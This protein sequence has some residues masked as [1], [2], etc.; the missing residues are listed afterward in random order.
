MSKNNSRK[1]VER[2]SQ[3]YTFSLGLS[4][5]FSVNCF[6]T[7]HLQFTM[8]RN[9]KG[10][11]GEE[12]RRTP[13]EKKTQAPDNIT[14]FVHKVLYLGRSRS[15]FCLQWAMQINS[16]RERGDESRQIELEK[17]RLN[18]TAMAETKRQRHRNITCYVS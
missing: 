3:Y 15:T 8:E 16:K 12:N 17:R 6:S 2:A 4:G 1:H 5:S 10:E 13:S 11:R 18:Q 9:S 14:Y 7:L